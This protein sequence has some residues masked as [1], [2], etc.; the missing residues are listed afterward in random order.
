M[1][2]EPSGINPGRGK[3]VPVG[4]HCVPK[5]EFPAKVSCCTFQGMP[6]GISELCNVGDRVLQVLPPFVLC[7]NAYDIAPLPD[8]LIG[9]LTTY[10]SLLLAGFTASWQLPLIAA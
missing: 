4:T 3:G 9:P 5:R 1:R 2:N 7:F 8:A 10:S 6:E